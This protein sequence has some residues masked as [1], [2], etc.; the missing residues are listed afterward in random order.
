MIG[1]KDFGSS[2]SEELSPEF[3]DV[4]RRAEQIL[5]GTSPPADNVFRVDVGELP[6]EIF[7]AISRFFGRW[8]PV[9]GWPT[10]NHVADIDLFS[11]NSA[12]LDDVVEEFS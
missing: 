1:A 3:S 11:L 12:G 8:L 2:V 9:S 7:P 5:C 4:F 6:V 10:A